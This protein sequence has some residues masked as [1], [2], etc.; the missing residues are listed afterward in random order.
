MAAA[1]IGFAGGVLAAIIS[2]IVAVRQRRS[3]ERLAELNADLETAVHERNALLDQR[4]TAEAVLARYSEPLAAAAY[5]LQSRLFNI[6][7][8][9]FFAR[10]GDGTPRAEE[11]LRTTVFRFAQY[12]GWTEILRR[13]VQFL[14]FPKREETREVAGLQLSIARCLLSDEGGHAMMIWSDQ[15]RAIG[16]QMIVEEHGKVLCMG[17]ARFTGC[18]DEVFGDWK[19]RIRIEIVSPEAQPRLRDLQHLLC[20]LVSRLDPD[21]LRYPRL[22]LAG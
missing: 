10:H 12:L 8:M 19:E 14:S 13:D 16:E 21:G 9:G 11:A 20:Q 3:D 17:Y 6:L 18:C 4:I 2:A 15:Q 1:W 22:D 5:D 7:S